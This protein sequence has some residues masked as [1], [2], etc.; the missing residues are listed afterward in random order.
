MTMRKILLVGVALLALA[1][2]C[3]QSDMM[4]AMA[5]PADEKL[6]TH[7]LDLLRQHQFDP[8]EKDVD[9]SIRTPNMHE[10]LVHM[11][12]AIPAQDPVSVKVV[13][14]NKAF[15]NRVESTNV[16]FEY[17]YPDRWLMEN[18]AIK[19][20]DGVSTIIGLNV[21]PLARSLEAENQ[22]T[23]AGKG[24]LQYAVLALAALFVITTLYALV[25]CAR[26]RIAKRKWLWIIFI[27][28]GFGKLSVN[29]TTGAWGFMPLAVQL[30]SAS[31]FSQPY[32]PWIVAVSF[33]LGAVW[34]LLRRKSLMNRVTPP[35]L[36]QTPPP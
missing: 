29:W 15:V 19:K 16:T 17:Q 22:F 36:P 7:Y 8:I 14:F 28:V 31:S 26:T 4:K 21:K 24:A 20:A 27:L 5:S 12:E 23:F 11:A 30:F 35:A 13:G 18:V 1:A 9:P 3:S 25:L 32:G 10:V 6:A 34:F 33:P 2:G